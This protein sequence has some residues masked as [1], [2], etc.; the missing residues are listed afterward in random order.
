MK[1]VITINCDNDV[2][3]PY[4]MEEVGRILMEL[5]GK[6][7]LRFSADGLKEINLKDR[8]GNPVGSLIVLDE[9]D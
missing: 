4:P 5:A 9:E 8:K 2:F 6:V 3:Q 7:P 1:V